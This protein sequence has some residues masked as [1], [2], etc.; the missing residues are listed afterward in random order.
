MLH[1]T[2]AYKAMQA[3]L[4]TLKCAN[5]ASLTILERYQPAARS[6]AIRT[7]Q[8]AKGA[9]SSRRLTFNSRRSTSNDAGKP[10]R[11]TPQ[12]FP[13]GMP[14]SPNCRVSTMATLAE[15]KPSAAVSSANLR[16]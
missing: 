4:A 2:A 12:M 13:S 9:S 14:I 6:P 1:I 10:I 11:H 5:P 16:S 7:A 15:S 8:P 3:R